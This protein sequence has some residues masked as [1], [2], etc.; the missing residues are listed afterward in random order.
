MSMINR[1]ASAQWN[2]NLKEGNGTV[3]VG[4][5][6]FEG[7]YS[8]PSRFE[9]G[10]GTNPEELIAAAH[11]ACFSMALSAGMSKDGLN[12]KRV[13]TTAEVTLDKVGEGFEITKI[14]LNTEADVPGLDEQKF[15]KY[16]EDAKAGCPISKALASVKSIE[17]NARLLA[18]V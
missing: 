4:S 3:K 7:N 10:T 1:N 16:A 2:G 6:V 9:S 5:G 14:V 15:Q 17:L 18:A 8:F 11:A 13:S 12:P